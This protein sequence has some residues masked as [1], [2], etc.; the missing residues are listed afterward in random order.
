MSFP[1]STHFLKM[2][3]NSSFGKCPQI[4]WV[5]WI[6]RTSLSQFQ[7]HSSHFNDGNNQNWKAS[8]TLLIF[9]FSH[10]I[11]RHNVILSEHPFSSLRGNTLSG[12]THYFHVL[13]SRKF[14]FHEQS[15]YL[16]SY[17]SHT[18]KHWTVLPFF[19]CFLHHLF[20]R[21]IHTT[22]FTKPAETRG[23][24]DMRYP[25]VLV[26]KIMNYRLHALCWNFS[27]WCYKSVQ[28]EWAP[29]LGQPL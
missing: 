1:S 10:E 27:G 17:T 8:F 2:V 5:S 21:N 12:N 4:V 15:K 23:I 9:L 3:V 14:F 11:L 13:I 22:V 16:F 7:P 28:R 18:P 29:V 19:A 24:F 26:G 6:T 20:S 25:Q